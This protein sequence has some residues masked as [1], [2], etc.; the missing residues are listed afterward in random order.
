MKKQLNY[1]IF[2]IL[3]VGNFTGYSQKKST[4]TKE[5]FRVNCKSFQGVNYVNEDI[6]LYS[7]R[8]KKAIYRTTDSTGCFDVLL[9]YGMYKFYAIRFGVKQRIS[10]KYF[11]EVYV[12]VH[13]PRNKHYRDDS[14]YFEYDWNYTIVDINYNSNSAKINTESYTVLDEIV[15]YLIKKPNI[16][17]EI[18]GHTDNSGNAQNNLILSKKRAESVKNY[19]VNNG[20]TSSRIFAKGYGHTIS[21]ADNSTEKSRAKN[22]RTEISIIQ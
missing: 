12:N 11:A 10:T 5:Y 1:I 3:L 2:L 4:A 6:I 17:I 8:L 21:I 19:L 15:N 13:G 7:K 22:R 14:L 18:G 16:K 9:P 20:I